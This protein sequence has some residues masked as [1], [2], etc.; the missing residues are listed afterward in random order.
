MKQLAA[1]AIVPPLA[2]T[3]RRGAIRHGLRQIKDPNQKH[4]VFLAWPLWKCD[5]RAHKVAF[6]DLD[7]AMA[8]KS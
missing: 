3:V 8:Q 2:E 7:A 4:A 5:W 6:A 1:T